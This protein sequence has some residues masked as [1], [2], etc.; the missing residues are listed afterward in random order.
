MNNKS[1]KKITI[2]IGIILLLVIGYFLLRP[3]EEQYFNKIT[4]PPTSVVT[5]Q[6]KDS[7]LDTIVHVGLNILEIDTVFVQIKKLPKSQK[8][9]DEDIDLVASIIS[10]GKNQFVIFVREN[11][12]RNENIEKISHELIHL[13]DYYTQKLI[14]FD[15]WGIIYGD[16]EWEDLRSMEY[17]DRP[18]E[19]EAF[20]EGPIL[21]KKI[22]NKLYTKD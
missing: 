20:K 19:I 7:Y 21:E 14:L 6:T 2:V 10:D 16:E 12:S 9:D 4:I 11:D 3:I 13:R 17:R 22:K 8:S 15:E 5:N 1:I 18:W